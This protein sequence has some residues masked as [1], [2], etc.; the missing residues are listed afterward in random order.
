MHTQTLLTHRV[1]SGYCLL[2][3]YIH[4]WILLSLFH[5]PSFAHSTSEDA[6]LHVSWPE[7]HS[8][9]CPP[10]HHSG[11]PGSMTDCRHGGI[12]R[13]T[14]GDTL[15]FQ[16]LI[17]QKLSSLTHSTKALSADKIKALRLLFLNG[18]LFTVLY[19]QP[20]RSID[21]GTTKTYCWMSHCIAPDKAKRGDLAQH[22]L[23]QVSSL[24]SCLV[25]RDVTQTPCQSFNPI[26][27]HSF[28]L[29][30]VI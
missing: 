30:H 15:E 4:V 19:R 22:I 17:I 21:M 24:F 14:P 10:C 11:S 8:Q 13:L 5:R 20:S 12:H 25:H 1:S 16:P 23:F 7:K 29:Q 9:P 27:T 28:S 6:A 3:F 26:K 18:A 2:V